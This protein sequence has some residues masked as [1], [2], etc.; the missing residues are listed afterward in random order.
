MGHFKNKTKTFISALLCITFCQ[1]SLAETSTPSNLA[2]LDKITAKKEN[3]LFR[4]HILNEFKMYFPQHNEALQNTIDDIVTN[5]MSVPTGQAIAKHILNCDHEKIFRHLGVSLKA[6]IYISERCH[7]KTA[8]DAPSYIHPSPNIKIDKMNTSIHDSNRKYAL[9]LT[10]SEIWAYDSWTNSNTNQ[11]NLIVRSNGS[12]SDLNKA[13]LT[14]LIAHETAVYFDA[15]FWV[16]S[17]DWKTI[18]E[19]SKLKFAN[20][21][22]DRFFAKQNSDDFLF[23]AL[24]NP[25]ISQ[26]LT[27]L[28]AFHIEKQWVTELIQAKKLQLKDNDYYNSELFN[29]IDITKCDEACLSQLISDRAQELLPSALPLVAFSPIYRSKKRKLILKDSQLRLK[30]KRYSEMHKILG[31]FSTQINKTYSTKKH[32]TILHVENESIGKYIE[33]ESFYALVTPKFLIDN[34]WDVIYLQNK[35]E[36]YFLK[37]DM[38]YLKNQTTY[39]E[40]E[41]NDQAKLGVFEYMSQPLLS[42]I[43]VK[44]SN[45]PRPRIRGGGLGR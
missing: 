7:A 33:K 10:E 9:V 27:F 31:D 15:K 35:F 16:D 12:Q 22:R 8:T 42:G 41:N 43:N 30:T 39:Y 11:T 38:S 19:L 20:K 44:F 28:R 37:D 40:N 4:D 17:E 13:F 14:K 5:L 21:Y 36:E 6:A 26:T 24:N 45:G 34:L 23:T 25:V 3:I 29:F 18:P 2:T 1:V 32:V